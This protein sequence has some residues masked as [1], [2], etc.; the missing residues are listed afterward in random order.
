M[1]LARLQVAALRE[2]PPVI[3]IEE[4]IKMETWLVDLERFAIRL[5]GQRHLSEWLKV[6]GQ[7]VVGT[8]ILGIHRNGLPEALDGVG[9]PLAPIVERSQI[10]ICV[11]A[12]GIESEGGFE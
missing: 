2:K 12:G 5:F 10:E 3:V 1:N 6:Q 4:S 8:G 9:R 7:V 11:G